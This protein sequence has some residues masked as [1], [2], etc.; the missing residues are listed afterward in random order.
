MGRVEFLG[1]EKGVPLFVGT[2]EGTKARRRPRF[3]GKTILKWTS[4]KR[5][6]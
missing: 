4:F 6:I 1:H 3:R 2:T 5:G